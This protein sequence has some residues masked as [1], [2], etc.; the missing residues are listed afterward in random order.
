MSEPNTAGFH[1]KLKR[2]V[3][4]LVLT[5]LYFA[6]WLCALMLLKVLILAEYKIEYRKFSLALVGALVLAKVVLVMEHIPLG[7]WIKRW[8]L[9]LDVI[10]RSLAYGIGVLVVLLLEK[11]FE[12]RH[13][14]GGFGAALY[15]IFQHRD[16]PH[17]WSNVMCVVSALLWFNVLTV[18]RRQL[19]AG[20]LMRIFLSPPPR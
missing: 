6:L 13:E 20:S 11:A 16:M 12:A 2:E 8:P 18:V 1:Q 4:A 3:I 19:G 10:V 15:G 17:I 7:T 14:Q 9:A 5:T